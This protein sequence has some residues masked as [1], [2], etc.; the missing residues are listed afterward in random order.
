ME[1]IVIDKE[2][3]E[4]LLSEI[5]KMYAFLKGGEIMLREDYN[6]FKEIMKEDEYEISNIS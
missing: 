3:K 1:S 2:F 5:N 6:E 4:H